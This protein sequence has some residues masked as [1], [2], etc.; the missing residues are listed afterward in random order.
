VTVKSVKKKVEGEKGI[1]GGNK[2]KKGKSFVHFENEW[3][4][5]RE[6]I[7]GGID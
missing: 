6:E 2:L 7:N 1:N 3:R 4:N 5:K